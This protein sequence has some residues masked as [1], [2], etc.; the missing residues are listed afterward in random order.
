[1]SIAAAASIA[2]CSDSTAPRPPLPPHFAQYLDSLYFA[3][4]S[5]STLSEDVRDSRT[6]MITQFEVGAAIG[7]PPKTLTVTTE[8]GTQLWIAYESLSVESQEHGAYINFLVAARDLSFRTY[9]Y[10]EYASDG[11]MDVA[12][13][14]DNDTVRTGSSQRDGSSIVSLDGSQVCPTPVSLN[15]PMISLA[16][17]STAKFSSSGSIVFND[18][19]GLEHAYRHLSFPTTAFEGE[20]F[21]YN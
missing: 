13:L 21:L 11:S 5:D 1:M 7:A 14:N 20:R 3:T 17:C 16:N 2:A 10:I 19:P 4:V 8:T 18:A 12:V 6:F 9:M 15:N